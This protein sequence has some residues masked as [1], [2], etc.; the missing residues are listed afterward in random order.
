MKRKLVVLILAAGK[1]KRLGGESQKVVKKLFDKPLLLY[2]IETVEMLKPDRIVLVVGHKKEEVFEQMKDRKVEYVE[3]QLPMGT[4]HAV[5]QADE[6]LKDYHG[7][8]LILCGDV[9][10]ITIS[11]LK[12]LIETHTSNRNC[13]TILTVYPENPFGYGRIIRNGKGTVESIAEE[14][15][16]TEEEKAI[17]EVNAGVYIFNKKKLFTALKYLKPDR[18][19][20]EYY[21]TDVVEILSSQGQ[22][23]N[24]YTTDKPEECIGI[25]T[26][27]D[28]RKAETLLRRIKYNG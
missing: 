21:F 3:Q 8:I 15:N 26:S 2:L 9:P 1:G 6:V 10:F 27:E 16:A 18:I 5:M 12:K 25:N 11:T 23:I 4:G 14:I 22:T 24:T 13:G 19:K 7:D 28:F 20:G 17:K